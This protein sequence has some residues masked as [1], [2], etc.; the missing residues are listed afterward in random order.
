M[1]GRLVGVLPLAGLRR[2]SSAERGGNEKRGGGG[3]QPPRKRTTPKTA[4]VVCVASLSRTGAQPFW[5]CAKLR[6]SEF[7][8]TSKEIQNCWHSIRSHNHSCNNMAKQWCLHSGRY[9]NVWAAGR[10]SSKVENSATVQ[11]PLLGHFVAAVVVASDCMPVMLNLLA[12]AWKF[13]R[14]ASTQA[15]SSSLLD[16]AGEGAAPPR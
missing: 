7:P 6:E 16:E 12:C 8:C 2:A 10:P 5:G 11:A 3:A 15:S 14:A 9:F 1:F 4:E 13:R